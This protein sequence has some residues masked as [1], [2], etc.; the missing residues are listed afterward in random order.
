MSS[1]SLGQMIGFIDDLF[2][3]PDHRSC[4]AAATQIEEVQV[5]AKD[6]GWV[7]LRWVT[8]EDNYRTLGLYDKLTK[9]S[10]GCV[11]K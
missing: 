8:S 7:V 6:Q 9:K 10:I 2:L 3:L 11:M 5:E 4:G 1:Q